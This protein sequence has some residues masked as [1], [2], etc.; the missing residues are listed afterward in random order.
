MRALLAVAI[1]LATTSGCYLP[2]GDGAKPVTRTDLSK[3]PYL[4]AGTTPVVVQRQEND[5]GV[6]ALAM[7]AGAWGKQWTLDDLEKALHPQGNGVRLGAMRD[8][9]R[10]RGLEAFAIKGTRADIEHELK[11][12]RPVLLGLVLP[13]DKEHNRTHYEVAIAIDP[14]SGDIVT[15]DPASGDMQKRQSNVFDLEW[16]TAGYATLVVVGDTS[17]QTARR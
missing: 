6:A 14:K 4:R 7:V 5:C 12:G 15:I 10:S 16:K 3:R 8:L 17:V 2:K 11:L 9:A 13:V 1:A